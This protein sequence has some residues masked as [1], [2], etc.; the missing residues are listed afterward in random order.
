MADQALQI[1]PRGQADDRLKLEGSDFAAGSA[2]GQQ[3]KRQL[4]RRVRASALRAQVNVVFRGEVDGGVRSDAEAV[5]NSSSQG[6]ID[7]G[8]GS[9]VKAPPLAIGGSTESLA[10]RHDLGEDSKL[11]TREST[12]GEDSEGQSNATPTN[13][14]MGVLSY[15][16]RMALKPHSPHPELWNVDG[17]EVDLLA[18][19]KLG[20]QLWYLQAE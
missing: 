5:V 8:A 7:G 4:R 13:T 10:R 14:T 9:V 11:E 12:S 15:A 19:Y 6:E 16:I 2:A 20:G 1:G 18:D 3:R 17:T